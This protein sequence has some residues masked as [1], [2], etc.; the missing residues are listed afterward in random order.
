MWACG[1]MCLRGLCVGCNVAVYRVVL[2]GL[3]ACV[4]YVFACDALCG[5]ALFGALSCVCVCV[6]VHC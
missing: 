6:C 4:W 2:L 3:F 5:V 1:L